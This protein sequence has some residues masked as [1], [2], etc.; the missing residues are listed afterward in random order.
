MSEL[1]RV[2]VVVGSLRAKSWSRKVATALIERA[3]KTLRPELIEIGDLPLCNEDRDGDAPPQAWA[4]FRDA[5]RG[6]DGVLFVTPEYNR[7][8]P[9]CLKNAIDVGS[10]PE[11]KSVWSGVPAGVVSVTPYKLGAFGAN[12]ALRQTFVFLNMP[13]M[14]QPEAYLGDVASLFDEGGKLKD[15]STGALLTKFMTAFD[16]W[17]DAVRGARAHGD[18]EAFLA[19]RASIARDYASGETKT[20]DA[21]LTARDPATFLS[22]RGDVVSGAE[23]VGARYRDDAKTFAPGGNSKLEILQSGWSGDLAF[24]TG[25]QHAEVTMA[26]SGERG[27]MTIH[28]TEV[29]RLEDGAYKLVHRHA[30]MAGK[31]DTKRD[32]R[33]KSA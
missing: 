16:R 23:K 22:P 17:I 18:F 15:E 32:K 31:S 14:Q 7:S 30:D 5:L 2:A 29:F 8:L 26:E 6:M 20:L 11:K 33:D 21:I 10:R 25:L 3:P 4:T 12:H 19:A 1:K 28:I 27:R 9:G 13:V 24:W